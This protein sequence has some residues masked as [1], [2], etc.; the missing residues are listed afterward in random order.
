MAC[1][2]AAP[3]ALLFPQAPAQVAVHTG[4]WLA[5]SWEGPG[6]AWTPRPE[7]TESLRVGQP[8]PRAQAAG[9]Q[10]EPLLS[11]GLLTLFLY[12]WLLRL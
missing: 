6:S 9:I 3:P 5:S 12:C 11:P 8:E 10:V 4:A 1:A 7:D 2:I